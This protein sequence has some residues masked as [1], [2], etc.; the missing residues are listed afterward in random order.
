MKIRYYTTAS[1]RSPVEDFISEMSDDTRHELLDALN[2]LTSGVNLQMP[3][4]RN[5][6]NIATGLHELRL[7][8]RS[9]QIRV[10]YYIRKGDAIFL[11]HAFRKKTQKMPLREIS[12]IRKRLKEI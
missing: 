8:D 10:I 12:I 9:G 4:S 11:L 7:R 2:L 5:L 1:G 3:V 6:A